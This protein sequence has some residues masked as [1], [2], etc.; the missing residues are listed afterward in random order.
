MPAEP[1]ERSFPAT[2]EAV[3]AARQFVDEHIADLDDRLR[4]DILV[5]VSE[6]TTNSIRHAGTPFVVS[7]QRGRRGDIRIEVCDENRS[8]PTSRNPRDDDA[9]GRGLRVVSA[10]AR[11]WG[12]EQTSTG[13]VVWARFVADRG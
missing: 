4:Q 9:G 1:Q 10:L 5:A 8:I 2:V 11:E 13:K 7:V 6:L 12:V 3:R